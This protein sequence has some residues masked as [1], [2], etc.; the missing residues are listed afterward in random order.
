MKDLEP[1]PIHCTVYELLQPLSSLWYRLGNALGLAPYLDKVRTNNHN[2]S[3]RLRAVLYHW[4]TSG[5]QV[6]PYTWDTL[7]AALASNQ[8]GA[9]HLA[10]EL[11]KKL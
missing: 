7:V 6:R 4:E 3:D 8:V 1:T 10:A 2:D 9:T 5:E 11:L